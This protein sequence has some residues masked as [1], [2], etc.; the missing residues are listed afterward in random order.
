[1][2]G[3][4]GRPRRYER[5][6]TIAYRPHVRVG[7]VIEARAKAVGLSKAEYTEYVMADLFGMPECAPDP[8]IDPDHGQE[9][10]IPDTAP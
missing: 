1:M 6:R 3:P 7:A 9:P 8:T 2:A 10:L 4:G 5:A